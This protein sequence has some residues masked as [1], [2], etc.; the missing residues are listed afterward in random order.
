MAT[1]RTGLPVPD[2]GASPNV[3][4]DMLTLA[5]KI[6]S[7]SV[8]QFASAAAR[9]AALSAMTTAGVPLFTTCTVAGVVQIKVGASWVAASSFAAPP[10]WTAIG[11]ILLSPWQ[12]LAQYP[13]YYRTWAGYVEFAGS[14]WQAGWAG[15]GAN[16]MANAIFVPVGVQSANYQGA[17]S[18]PLTMVDSGLTNQRDCTI[19]VVQ[20]GTVVIRAASTPVAATIVNFDNIR[21]RVT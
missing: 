11:S 9:D 6:D 3:P 13:L 14:V 1:S 16:I 20:N 19:S 7:V 5:N 8:P 2:L 18:I 10:A 15:A 4:A 12:I 17:L 21:W